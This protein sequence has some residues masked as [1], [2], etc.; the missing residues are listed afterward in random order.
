MSAAEQ[1]ALNE[2]VRARLDVQWAAFAEHHPHLA[3]AVER[4]TLIEQ[5][6]DRLADDERFVAAMGQAAA[7]RRTLDAAGD[8]V[9]IVDALVRR[10][11]GIGLKGSR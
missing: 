6:V 11:L 2:L 8:V 4:T 9:E 10:V 5:V 1:K 3:K 7:D